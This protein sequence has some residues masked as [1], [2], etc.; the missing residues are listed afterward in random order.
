MTVI[1]SALEYGLYAT[2]RGDHDEWRNLKLERRPAAG[3][4]NKNNW[5][6]AWNRSEQRLARNKDAGRLAEYH[7]NI[8]A[9]VIDSLKEHQP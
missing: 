4:N 2:H 9:W 5:W 7:P 3:G 1:A 6:L 8:F